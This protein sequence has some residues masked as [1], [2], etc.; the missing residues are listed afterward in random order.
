MECHS[1]FEQRMHESSSLTPWTKVHS[2]KV[3]TGKLIKTPRH[4][5]ETKI[6][7]RVYLEDLGVDGRYTQK[8][9]MKLSQL[10]KI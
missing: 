9:V 2:K 5:K 4:F 6:D 1:G 8:H 10:C 3:I 7:D